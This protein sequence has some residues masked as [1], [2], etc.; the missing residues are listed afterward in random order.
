MMGMM[1]N[2]MGGPMGYGPMMGDPSMMMMGPMGF[3][4][5]NPSVEMG[6]LQFCYFEN[7]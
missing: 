2:I 5:V 4:Q 7:S 3:N 6:N 1:P